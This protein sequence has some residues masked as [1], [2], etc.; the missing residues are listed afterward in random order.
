MIEVF[1]KYRTENIIMD[2]KYVFVAFKTKMHGITQ[3]KSQKHYPVV[4][5][6]SLLHPSLSQLPIELW[7]PS[8]RAVHSVFF[9]NELFIFLCEFSIPILNFL[10]EILQLS[11]LF[12]PALSGGFCFW[13][14]VVSW[15][16]TS[17][18]STELI[19]SNASA[20]LWAAL[21]SLPSTLPFLFLFFSVNIY[22]FYQHPLTSAHS[23]MVLQH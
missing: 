21:I 8:A 18:S 6:S 4:Y 7:A 12:L 5:S 22:I 2:F 14:P 15:S 17:G 20:W 16:F 9:I 19:R 1:T 13:P 11:P 3:K 10:R 23:E